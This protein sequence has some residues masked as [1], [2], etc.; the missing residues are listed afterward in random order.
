MSLL[1][2]CW[3]RPCF[4]FYTSSVFFPTWF[5]LV[6][7]GGRSSL[8][9]YLP[10]LL[11]FALRTTVPWGVRRG[12]GP[13]SLR[14]LTRIPLGRQEQ[15]DSLRSWGVLPIPSGATQSACLGIL[16]AGPRNTTCLAVSFSLASWTERPHFQGMC[17]VSYLIHSLPHEVLL[18]GNIETN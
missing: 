2:L 12:R 11:I 6:T 17:P 15:G 10:S 5:I 1:K 14:L 3:N 13:S 4:L 7:A 16:K 8:L 9:K 18:H